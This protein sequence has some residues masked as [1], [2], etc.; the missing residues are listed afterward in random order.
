MTSVDYLRL[1]GVID[2]LGW[3]TVLAGPATATEPDAEE[4][5]AR[6]ALRDPC[7]MRAG[8]DRPNPT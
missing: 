4:I 2:R 8:F 6:L 1:R 3:L 5:S 7:V